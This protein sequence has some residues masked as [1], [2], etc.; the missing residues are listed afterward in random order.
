M[1]ETLTERFLLSFPKGDPGPAGPR[2]PRGYAGP[3]GATGAI[4]PTGVTGNTGLTGATGA[5]GAIGP[6]GPTGATG[7]TGAQGIPGDTGA[8]GAVGATGPQGE[9]GPTGVTGETGPAGEIGPTGPQGVP[10]YPGIDASLGTLIWRQEEGL[11]FEDEVFETLTTDG[12]TPELD[13][14]N[15]PQIP[16][17]DGIYFFV[18]NVSARLGAVISPAAPAGSEIEAYRISGIAH[19]ISGVVSLSYVNTEILYTSPGN[20]SSFDVTVDVA[21][22]ELFIYGECVF[23]DEDDPPLG[24]THAVRWS[25]LFQVT[26]IS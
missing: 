8:T 26:P 18:L 16:A 20:L 13:Y 3:T 1:P 19:R 7:G 22:D 15:M 21:D 4:G 6:Q 12:L 10:G 11:G 5:T 17:S 2:G 9:T 25:G 23:G 24:Y 14:D